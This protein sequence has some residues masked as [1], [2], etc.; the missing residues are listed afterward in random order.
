MEFQRFLAQG[1]TLTLKPLFWKFCLG[2]NGVKLSFR[3]ASI[4]LLMM[5]AAAPLSSYSMFWLAA[6]ISPE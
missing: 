4:S 2:K 6:S 3:G 1:L 5:G